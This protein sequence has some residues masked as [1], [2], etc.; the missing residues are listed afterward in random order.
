M[1][2]RITVRG[3]KVELRGYV[4]AAD[5]AEIDA[6]LAELNRFGTA[7]ES[8]VVYSPALDEYNPFA[9]EDL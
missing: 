5:S 8:M 1:K 2:F 7:T 3:Q 9:L 4:E 6:M